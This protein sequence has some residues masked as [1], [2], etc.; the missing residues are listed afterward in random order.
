MKP[1]I[2]NIL[3]IQYILKHE[4]SAFIGLGQIFLKSIITEQTTV[5]IYRN[6]I[7]TVKI[8]SWEIYI[9]L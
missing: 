1:S 3:Y 5:I 6:K 2:I 8:F 9:L 7:D 4:F